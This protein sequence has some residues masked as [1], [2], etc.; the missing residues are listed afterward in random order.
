MQGD[1]FVF[2]LS[3]LMK[4]GAVDTKQR[5]GYQKIWEGKQWKMD[6]I[7]RGIELNKS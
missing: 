4:L 3:V 6:M 2:F 5:P 1:G 7:E